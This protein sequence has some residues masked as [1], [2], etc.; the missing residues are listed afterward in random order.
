MGQHKKTEKEIATQNGVGDATRQKSFGSTP[1]D[2]GL[3]KGAKMATFGYK[4]RGAGQIW[5]GQ[6]TSP[7]V[8]SNWPE[9]RTMGG[10]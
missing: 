3:S 7:D 4:I 5:P 9:N 6:V 1:A 2:I 10:K 8:K